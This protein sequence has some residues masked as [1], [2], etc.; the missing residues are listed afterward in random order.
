M[1]LQQC[2]RD[3]K[4][5]P[6]SVIAS[7]YSDILCQVCMGFPKL[8][9]F[10]CGSMPPCP[11]QFARSNAAYP[12][13]LASTYTWLGNK[14]YARWE[15]LCSGDENVT[16]DKTRSTEGRFLSDKEHG[17]LHLQVLHMLFLLSLQRFMNVIFQGTECCNRGWAG[18]CVSPG[19]RRVS[20]IHVGIYVLGLFDII[21]PVCKC[22]IDDL[23]C[24]RLA[25]SIV[26]RT[27]LRELRLGDL[28]LAETPSPDMPAPGIR[29]NAYGKAP[30]KV[31]SS[32][33]T[34]RR[35]LVESPE[36]NTSSRRSSWRGDN[37]H[38]HSPYKASV[39]NTPY[40][41]SLG[42][43][44]TPCFRESLMSP[45]HFLLW[46]LAKKEYLTSELISKSED[47]MCKSESY[48]SFFESLSV[49]CLQTALVSTIRASSHDFECC[50]FWQGLSSMTL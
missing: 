15:I 27:P 48:V 31:H 5:L 34:I 39:S 7:L 16:P 49:Q 47:T 21:S 2:H 23:S 19:T 1:S 13:H 30:P 20:L 26:Q 3:A 38:E 36:T 14:S 6:C 22:L 29:S 35:V 18:Y 12:K 41:P 45:Q 43:N 8:F 44:L 10:V 40:Q 37:A 25:K 32:C 50:G 42:D 4:P 17:I 11:A 33:R 28:N 24:E 9:K 46:R